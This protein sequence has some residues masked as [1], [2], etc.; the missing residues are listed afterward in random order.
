MSIRP[1][2]IRGRG[3][4]FRVRDHRAP[5]PHPSIVQHPHHAKKKVQQESKSLGTADTLTSPVGKR[6]HRRGDDVLLDSCSTPARL[7]L[8]SC[9][10]GC[11]TTVL[12]PQPLPPHH[13]TP[14]TPTHVCYPTTLPATQPSCHSFTGAVHYP[15]NISSSPPS[16]SVHS[17]LIL[18]AR[19]AASRGDP[20]R[21]QLLPLPRPTQ[22][23]QS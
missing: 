16:S 18:P 6:P 7:L 23:L 15:A 14:P 19:T 21:T 1:G 12:K 4:K 11:S 17:T 22:H 5:Q 10:R 20:L 3:P 8:D 2:E 13:T 9:M